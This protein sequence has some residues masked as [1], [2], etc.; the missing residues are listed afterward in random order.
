VEKIR[1]QVPI[2]YGL[3]FD[4]EVDS[5]RAFLLKIAHRLKNANARLPSLKTSSPH[6]ERSTKRPSVSSAT[7][8]RPIA[9]KIGHYVPFKQS[10]LKG[11]T[12]PL[13]PPLHVETVLLGRALGQP[14]GYVLGVGF[15]VQDDGC[16]EAEF[17]DGV[18][19]YDTYEKF[20][21]EVTNLVGRIGR[22]NAEPR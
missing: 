14:T 22:A 8:D 3:H 20:E 7:K 17:A 11:Q 6:D 16:V 12:N 19:K 18:R 21:V 13:R 2:G 1:R 10:R 4:Y 15:R 5:H 9:G